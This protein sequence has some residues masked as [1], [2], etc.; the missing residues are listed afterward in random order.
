MAVYNFDKGLEE[1]RADLE[2]VEVGAL[3]LGCSGAGKSRALGTFGVKTLYLYTGGEDHGPASA[4]VAGG[5]DISPYRLDILDNAELD[6]STEAGA[7][8]IYDHLL[9]VL[10]ALDWIKSKGYGAIGLDSLTELENLVRKTSYWKKACLTPK[11]AHNTY[12]ET[13]AAMDL[14]RPVIEALKKLR[15]D[16]K[17][18]FAITCILDVKTLSI[19]GEIEEASPHLT[20]YMLAVSVCQLLRDIIIVGRMERNGEVKY[21]FQFGT[22]IVKASKDEQGKLKKTTNF[23]PRLTPGNPLPLMEADFKEIIKNKKGEK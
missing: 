4:S 11:G 12:A 23:A 18:H 9:A 19:N 15:R 7:D 22:E 21:K 1:A 17:I 2:C 6:V 16:L 13:T 3:L 10:K 8:A 14:I 5:S 20:G